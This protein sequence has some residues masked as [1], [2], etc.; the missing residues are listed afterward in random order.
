MRFAFVVMLTT[1]LARCAAPPPLVILATVDGPPVWPTGYLLGGTDG[2]PLVAH[3][4]TCAH[5]LASFHEGFHA[6]WAYPPSGAARGQGSLLTLARREGW[7]TGVFAAASDTLRPV[8]ERLGRCAETVSIHPSGDAGWASALAAARLWAATNRA[9]RF[10]AVHFSLQNLSAGSTGAAALVAF[11]N[12]LSALVRDSGAHS[13]LVGVYVRDWSMPLDAEGG[14]RLR[15]T[16]WIPGS[17]PPG[18]TILSTLDVAP[19]VAGVLGLLYT[20]DYPGQSLAVHASGIRVEPVVFARQGHRLV[21][22][23]R[24]LLVLDRLQDPALPDRMRL[25]DLWR[26]EFSARGSREPEALAL[27]RAIPG[28]GESPLQEGQHPVP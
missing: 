14:A 12:A 8:F 17:P 22:G 19:T 6:P 9:P 3:S 28:R 10:A 27:L 15:V 7:A 26:G 20:P 23:Q 25:F 1:L 11:W 5:L 16:G 13:A 4:D 21:M 18:G 24:W 2:W